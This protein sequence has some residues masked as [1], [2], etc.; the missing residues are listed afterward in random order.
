M[1]TFLDLLNRALFCNFSIK[2]EMGGVLAAPPPAHHAAL[3]IE[4]VH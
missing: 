3:L 4:K 2:G 1:S